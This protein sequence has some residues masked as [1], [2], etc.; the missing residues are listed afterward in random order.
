MVRATELAIPTS[1]DAFRS[2]A[3]M[4]AAAAQ[5]L[6][7]RLVML[8]GEN[9]ETTRSERHRYHAGQRS[10]CRGRRRS[11][12]CE[13]SMGTSRSLPPRAGVWRRPRRPR[14]GPG[15]LASALSWVL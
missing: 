13:A 4:V 10:A 14:S 5:A 1:S 8:L 9:T 2:V 15:S 6:V 11:P 7:P 12:S 3:L